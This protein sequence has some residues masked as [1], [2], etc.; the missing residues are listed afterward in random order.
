MMMRT[1]RSAGLSACRV[2]GRVAEGSATQCPRCGQRFFQREHELQTVWAWLVAGLVCYV[3]A[4]LYPMLLTKTITTSEAK[5]TIMQGVVELIGHHEYAVA[6]I[7]FFA[8]VVVPVGKFIATG[9]LAF[10]LR[11]H[12]TLSSHRRH[13]LLDVVEFIGRWSMIDVF[14][15][16]IL[17]SLVQLG[18]VAQIHP[19]PAAILFALSVVFTMRAA[20]CFDPRLIWEK[21]DSV[22]S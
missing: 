2:C 14:V 13:Q 17:S 10:S 11:K 20:Q 21:D 12:A 3:P 5:N 9:F 7:V 4:N 19:G 15:V 18:S 22:P 1:A 8:S 16:A 6:F